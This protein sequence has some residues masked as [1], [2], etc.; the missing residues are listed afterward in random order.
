MTTKLKCKECLK[1][2]MSSDATQKFHNRECYRINMSK[3]YPQ[4][5][6]K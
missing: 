6:L 2:F 4:V 1:D 3:T 5:K